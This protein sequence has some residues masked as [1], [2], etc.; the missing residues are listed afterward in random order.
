MCFIFECTSLCAVVAAAW[1]RIPVSDC[2]PE[3]DE[4]ALVI[5][6]SLMTSPD[7]A[8][9]LPP[10]SQPDSRRRLNTYN[11]VPPLHS[12]SQVHMRW[13]GLWKENKFTWSQYTGNASSITDYH[14]WSAKCF[15]FVISLAMFALISEIWAFYPFRGWSHKFISC[16]VSVFWWS[17]NNTSSMPHWRVNI[18]QRQK[19]KKK[20]SFWLK[21]NWNRIYE[22]EMLQCAKARAQAKQ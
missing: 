8:R 14:P 9:L 18:A 7:S 16:K 15:C 12:L 3:R 2:E 1:S 4:E 6:H 17:N 11:C 10:A 5:R 20:N 21:K 19:R 22:K 13:L